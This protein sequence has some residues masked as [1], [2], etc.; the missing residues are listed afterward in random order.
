MNTYATTL[1]NVQLSLNQ[2]GVLDVKFLFKRESLGKPMTDL[3]RDLADVLS[4]FLDGKAENVEQLPS[5]NLSA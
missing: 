4:K 5:E 2:S 1:K 3:E